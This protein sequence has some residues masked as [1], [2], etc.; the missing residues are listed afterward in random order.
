MN[1]YSIVARLRI[2]LLA[3]ACFGVL[4]DAYAGNYPDHAIHIVVPLPPGASVDALA[5]VLA[6]PLG[7]RLKQPIVIDNKPGGNMII[8]AQAVA[9]SPPDGYTLFLTMD[10]PLVANPFLYTRLSYDAENDFTAISLLATSPMLIA[11]GS[12]L[13]KKSIQDFLAYAKGNPG[14][15]SYGG[16][17]VAAQVVGENLRRDAGIDM[18]YVPFRGGSPV[19]QALLGGTISLSIT[20]ITPALP[21]IRNGRLTALGVTGSHRDPSLPNVPTLVEEGHKDMD[22]T[23]WIGL[24]APAKTP[25][26][27]VKRLNEELVGIMS[28]PE[29]RKKILEL[30]LDPMTSSPAEMTDRIKLDRSKW[31]KIIR[32]SGVTIN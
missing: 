29:I 3:L 12:Q 25:E 26:A 5:R 22:I 31:G 21:W 32:A 6:G 4:P 17:V 19:I 23:N 28:R 7:D 30:T 2:C 10:L 11:V 16:G 24:V 13:Q 9:Q 18:V 20:D 1:F 14:K 8:A 27:I 15:L